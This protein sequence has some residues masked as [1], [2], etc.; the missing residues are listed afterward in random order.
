MGRA[1]SGIGSK[2]GYQDAITPPWQTNLALA[3]YLG[4]PGIIAVAWWFVG[5]VTAFFVFLVLAVATIAIGFFLPKPGSE[6]YQRL[7]LRS[8][9]RRYADFVKSGDV[10]R[11]EAM[12]MLLKKAGIDPDVIRDA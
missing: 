10:V 3:A 8:M 2:T 12:K 4:V 6:H 7:I 1:L 9:S 11:A 5:L